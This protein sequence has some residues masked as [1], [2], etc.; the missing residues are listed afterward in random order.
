[1]NKKNIIKNLFFILFLLLI[2]NCSN[3]NNDIKKKID[4][5]FFIQ[6]IEGG[7]CE[8]PDEVCGS[9]TTIY[10]SGFI[11]KTGFEDKNWSIEKVEVEDL[12]K[13]LSTILNDNCEEP[14]NYDSIIEYTI[15][16]NNKTKIFEDPGCIYAIDKINEVVFR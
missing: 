1:M 6:I 15:N 14:Q 7:Y 10:D 3:L 12:K 11:V 9:I 8:E 4:N 5:D 13:Y 16:L 2:S